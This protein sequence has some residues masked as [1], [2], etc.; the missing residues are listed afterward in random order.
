LAWVLG[1]VAG[2]SAGGASGWGERDRDR[3]RRPPSDRQ[4]DTGR[5]RVVEPA[6]DGLGNRPEPDTF[7][8]VVVGLGVELGRW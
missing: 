7:T 1:R 4:S 2:W 3:L 5:S 8:F 6:P